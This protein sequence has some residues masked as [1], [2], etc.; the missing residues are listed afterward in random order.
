M[1]K[2]DCVRKVF[3]LIVAVAIC[4]SFTGCGQSAEPAKTDGGQTN[5]AVMEG[6]KFDHKFVSGTLVK[7]WTFIPDPKNEIFATISSPMGDKTIMMKFEWQNTTDPKKQ[8]EDFVKSFP[9]LKPTPAEQVKYGNNEFWKTSYENSGYK[10]VQLHG[11]T[12]EILSTLTLTG[13]G[14]D[15]DPD[16]AQMLSNMTFKDVKLEELNK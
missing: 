2:E 16:M 10:M 1:L 14:A 8:T 15:T 3:M 4:V 7:G 11:M 5:N 6:E 9:E 12:G 13:N